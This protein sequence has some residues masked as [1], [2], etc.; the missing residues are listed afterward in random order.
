MLLLIARVLF[1]F[2]SVVCRVLLFLI[3]GFGFV[4]LDLLVALGLWFECCVLLCIVL[5]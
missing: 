4:L 2:N 5:C 1:G 3:C